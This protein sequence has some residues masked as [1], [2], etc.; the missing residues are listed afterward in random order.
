MTKMTCC[1]SALVG[2]CGSAVLQ[3]P[4]IDKTLW[5]C[6]ELNIKNL[7]ETIYTFGIW[8]NLLRGCHKYLATMIFNNEIRM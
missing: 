4:V 6:G 7:G 8:V 2:G 3:W 1:D 5:H